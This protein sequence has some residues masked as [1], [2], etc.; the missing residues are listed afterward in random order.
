MSNLTPIAYTYDADVH[1]PA[2]AEHKFG[3]GPGGWIAE[4]CEDSEGNPVGVVA[5]WDEWEGDMWCGT[6]LLLIREAFDD[7]PPEPPEGWAESQAI[8]ERNQRNLGFTDGTPGPT[9]RD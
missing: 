2:C 1:C 7:G 6:C 8:Y 4:D 3:R 5:P 9:E